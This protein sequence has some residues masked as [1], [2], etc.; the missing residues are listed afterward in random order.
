MSIPYIYN[1]L[2]SAG[3]GGGD[4]S[5]ITDGLFYHID[6][7]EY[8]NLEPEDLYDLVSHASYR[9]NTTN[10]QNSSNIGIWCINI[11]GSGY[12]GGFISYP[13]HF[14]YKNSTVEVCCFPMVSSTRDAIDVNPWNESFKSCTR[15]SSDGHRV[16]TSLK[17]TGDLNETAIIYPSTW[18]VGTDAQYHVKK[19]TNPSSPLTIAFQYNTVPTI[20]VDGSISSASIYTPSTY[21]YMCFALDNVVAITGRGPYLYAIRWYSRKLSADELSHN[22]AVDK[23]RYRQKYLNVLNGN[24]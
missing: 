14:S 8:D 3:S 6:T 20:S 15:H 21:G 22:A 10:I 9:N 12:V 11:S 7:N 24:Y 5:Y 4:G 16:G 13:N 17:I 2:G 19:I 23:I 1:P 18:P